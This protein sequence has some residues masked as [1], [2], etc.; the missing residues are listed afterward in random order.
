MLDTPW[1]LKGVV[2]LGT[3]TLVWLAVLLPL[4]I[5]LE[6]IAPLDQPGLRRT[7]LQWSIVGWADTAL[8]LYGLLAMVT[9]R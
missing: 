5:R 2:A 3:A 1:L 9:K 7:F 6:R 8:L 4:Q